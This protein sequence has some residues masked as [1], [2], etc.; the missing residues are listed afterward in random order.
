MSFMS[1]KFKMELTWHS[2]DT[3]PPEEDYN[4]YLLITDGD[5]VVAS[6]W[7]KD[8][9]W[10]IFGKW[11]VA[12]KLGGGLCWWADLKQTVRKTSEFKR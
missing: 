10:Y 3:C 12:P 11:Y 1:N 4:P 7:R 6:V 5:T 2:C 9:G 8:C